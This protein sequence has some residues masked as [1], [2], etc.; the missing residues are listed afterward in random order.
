MSALDRYKGRVLNNELRKSQDGT[1][2]MALKQKHR[3][4]VQGYGPSSLLLL[5]VGRVLTSMGEYLMGA[6]I[7]LSKAAFPNLFPND[8]LSN[9]VFPVPRT[10]RGGLGRRSVRHRY[11]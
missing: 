2:H 11:V 5:V 4:A 10:P 8:K 7:D 3:M 1:M 9:S 6:R